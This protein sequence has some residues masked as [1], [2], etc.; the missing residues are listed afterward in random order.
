VH[1]GFGKVWSIHEVFHFSVGPSQLVLVN[2][3]LDFVNGF[4]QVDLLLL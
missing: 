2:E 1:S 3:T 4:V